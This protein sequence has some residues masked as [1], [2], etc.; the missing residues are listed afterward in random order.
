MKKNKIKVDDEVLVYVNTREDTFK[1][2]VVEVNASVAKD[3]WYKVQP[4]GQGVAAGKSFWHR[5]HYVRKVN[6]FDE[7]DS[8][9]D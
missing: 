1:G 3:V 9:G 5:E 6:R 7:L 8:I 4:Y 2:R